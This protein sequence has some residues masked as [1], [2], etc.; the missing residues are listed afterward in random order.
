MSNRPSTPS[1]PNMPHMPST[2]LNLETVRGMATQ[3]GL[4]RL[5]PEHLQELLRATLAA[6]ARQG[7]LPFG[8]LTPADEPSHA[9][10]LPQDA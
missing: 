10:R 7:V 6:Q 5:H 4:D 2:P 1:T 8:D 3:I 9:Y